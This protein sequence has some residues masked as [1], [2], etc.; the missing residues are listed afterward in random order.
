MISVRDNEKN[1][2]K[3]KDKKKQSITNSVLIS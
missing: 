3:N 1:T 2:G